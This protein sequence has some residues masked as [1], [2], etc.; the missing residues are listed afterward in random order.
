MES[1]RS[2]HPGAA[3]HPSLSKEGKFH[4]LHRSAIVGSLLS[5]P[6]ASC[7]SEQAT[8]DTPA[9]D[10][11]T[12]PAG[13]RDVRT[14]LEQ[15]NRFTAQGDDDRAIAAFNEALAINPKD[16]EAYNN[17]GV[18]YE[19]RRDHDRAVADFTMAISL[20]N[21]YVEA[22]NN[23]G[24]AYKNK[25]D[26]DRAINDFNKALQLNPNHII[27]YYNRGVA[28]QNKGS[29]TQAIVDFDKVLADK[30]QDAVTS[31]FNVVINQ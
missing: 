4:N 16:A 9:Q 6:T 14:Y 28:Y 25:G 2:N 19:Y 17:R 13:G 12:K 24:V 22:Y 31:P 7:A 11:G 8:A 26:Y 18:V 5:L 30:P 3:R 21:D 20:N 23:R 29:Y 27:A 1:P 10:T 15:G